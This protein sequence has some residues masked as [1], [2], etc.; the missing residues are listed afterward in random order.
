MPECVTN[1][2]S[3]YGQGINE[4]LNQVAVVTVAFVSVARRQASDALT[5][6][7]YRGL[8]GQRMKEALPLERKAA[9]G[10]TNRHCA[11]NNENGRMSM[12]MNLQID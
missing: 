3:G 12:S 11:L 6:A 2:P 7:H 4:P 10:S 8:Q 1:R 5:I 9:A